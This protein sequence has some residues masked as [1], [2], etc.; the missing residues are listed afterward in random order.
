MYAV[1]SCT[2]KRIP[3]CHAHR[4]RYLCL[5]IFVLYFSSVSVFVPLYD[6]Y[7]VSKK[8][9]YKLFAKFLKINS[10]VIQ[11]YIVIKCY[12]RGERQPIRLLCFRKQSP[13]K[14]FIDCLISCHTTLT[15]N[16][17]KLV[18]DI[19]ST[20]FSYSSNKVDMN[21]K[22]CKSLPFIMYNMRWKF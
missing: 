12:L 18:D 20:R 16:K 9:T 19:L 8:K 3:F 1:L 11:K 6:L 4:S 15:R 22:I 14:S 13:V 17:C 10:Y 2:R 7:V 21:L 5:S